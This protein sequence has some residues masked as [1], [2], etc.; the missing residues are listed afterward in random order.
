MSGN[1]LAK[2]SPALTV[3]Q[4]DTHFPRIPGD[5][6]SPDTY[7]KPISVIPVKDASVAEI[8]TT[9]PEAVSI[10]GFEDAVADITTGIGVTSCGFLGYWQDHLNALCPQE[11]LTSS[12]ISCNEWTAPYDAH[13]TVIVTFD[14]E[15]LRAPH[16]STLLSGFDGRIIGLDPDMHLRDVI[17]HDKDDLDQDRATQEII[18]LLHPY[19]H[20]G[21][22]KALI[23]ECTNL[24][25]YKAALKERYNVAVFD[26]LT[27]ISSHNPNLVNPRFL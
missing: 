4:L 25:P 19:L 1:P 17:T 6:A 22:I 15:A 3:L 5:V 18:D 16:Y 2:D 21:K 14:D 8:V 26:I 10:K 12:L 24:P 7:L 11:F 9:R 27:L 13:E 20:A 23:L